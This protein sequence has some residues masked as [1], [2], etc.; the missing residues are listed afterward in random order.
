MRR[1]MFIMLSL[2]FV[3]VS[4]NAQGSG[5]GVGLSS[6][7]LEGKYWMGGNALA[8]HWN[9]GSHIAADYLLNQPDMVK[10]T[11]APT[12]VYYGVGIGLGTY[13]GLNDDFEE[14]TELDLNVRGVVGIGYYVSAFP[15]DIY[16][17]LVP[18]LGVLGGTGFGVGGTFGFRY[19][20]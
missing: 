1:L 15:V 14:T 16:L 7:G 6:D 17:E 4:V 9:L 18:S 8:I 12:P 3:V 19:F 2:I 13:K 20:F 11:D 5:I 10:L